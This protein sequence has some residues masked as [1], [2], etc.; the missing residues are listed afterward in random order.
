MTPVKMFLAGGFSGAMCTFVVCPVERI[1]CLLQVASFVVQ[2]VET[3]LRF[4]F[5]ASQIQAGK[6]P[7]PGESVY[8]GPL[9]CGRQLLRTGGISSL[10]RGLG[11]TFIRGV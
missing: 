1:K 5:F 4:L 6:A 11:A 3:P 7:L 8:T 2:F 9:D 10:Y